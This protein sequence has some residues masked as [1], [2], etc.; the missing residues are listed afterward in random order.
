MKFLKL[1]I[2]GLILAGAV[3]LFIEG[4][5]SY[6]VWSVLLSGLLVLFHFKNLKNIVALLLVRKSKF[7]AAE[8][9]LATV[10]HPENLIARQEGYYYYLCG[11]VATQK[12]EISKAEKLLKKALKS[13]LKMKMDQAVANLNLAGIA[14][15]K[16]NKKLAVIYIR[17]CKKLDTRKM[18]TSQ[19]KEVEYMM[20]RA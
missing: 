13:G 8:K 5:I 14:L 1:I 12:Q 9:V 16:R 15:S 3:Y 19:I 2:A 4:E 17:E 10:K 18:L 7:D 11:L 20:K 6:G